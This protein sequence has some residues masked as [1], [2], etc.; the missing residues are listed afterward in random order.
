MNHDDNCLNTTT[1][2]ACNTIHGSMVLFKCAFGMDES[3]QFILLFSLFLLLFM[4]HNALFCTIYESQCI[5]SANFYF[6]LQYF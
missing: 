5:I 3:C 1:S 2:F 6:Y 4:S